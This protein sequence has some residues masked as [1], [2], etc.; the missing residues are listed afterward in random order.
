MFTLQAPLPTV[1]TT[2]VLPNPQFRNSES[3]MVELIGGQPARS[4]DGTVRTYIRRKGRR[5]F[6]WTFILTRNKATEVREFVRSYHSSEIRIED[7]EGRIVEGWIMNNP[8]E[9]NMVRRAGEGI[10]ELPRGESCEVTIEFEGEVTL[11]PRDSIIA[12]LGANNELGLNQV[13]GG[14]RG[15]PNI[16]G[17]IHDWD[18]LS[19]GGVD[20]DDRIT[21]VTDN[22]SA[23][24]PL[25]PRPSATF[26]LPDTIDFAP[27]Y[28]R[29][30]IAPG[31]PSIYFGRTDG[32]IYTTTTSVYSQSTTSLFPNKR[33]TVFWVFKHTV[34]DPQGSG[35]T[36]FW[37]SATE[38]GFWSMKT[39]SQSLPAE[40]FN[41][42]G[43]ANGLRPATFRMQPESISIPLASPT[44]S[45]PT[46]G[47]INSTDERAEPLALVRGRTYVHMIQRNSD[48]NIRWRVNGLEQLG[49]T[50]P[51]NPGASGTF[52]IGDNSELV[53]GFSAVLRGHLGQ[54]MVFNR[55]LS[56]AEIGQVEE[57]LALK[58][59]VPLGTLPIHS[60][61]CFND[62]CIEA[63]QFCGWDRTG[64]LNQSS[65]D[66]LD[67]QGVDTECEPCCGQ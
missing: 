4:I 21:T 61:Q 54:F 35:G 23:N 37:Q 8:L 19:I 51:N 53:T 13:L 14:D 3:A 55:A 60:E 6:V 63:P 22:G 1:K 39:A 56:S 25:I 57:Y 2:S 38:F 17:L 11:A 48:T 40:S 5:R 44:D 49:R 10:Q 26:N 43:G 62:Y 32:S 46:V 18:M 24:I 66:F 16:S 52:R 41:V 30:I 20:Q 42:N 27:R 31:M 15:Q 28:Y 9:I 65:Q 50:A 47:N 67:S 64:T 7:H 33:G 45:Y 29:G 12:L 59:N 34:G 36:Q 58:W